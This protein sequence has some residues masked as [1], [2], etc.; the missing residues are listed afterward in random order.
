[1]HTCPHCH[2]PMPDHRCRNGPYRLRSGR[3]LLGVCGGIADYFGWSRTWVRIVVA[4]LALCTFSV[5]FVGYFI[6]ALLMDEEIE[7]AD[8]YCP[9]PDQQA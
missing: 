3:K 6:A 9:Q 4:L 2:R 5:I 1:M 8:H 7:S